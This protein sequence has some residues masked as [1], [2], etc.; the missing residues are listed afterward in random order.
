MRAETHGPGSSQR[1]VERTHL[2]SPVP[3]WAE[4][5]HAAS[6][7]DYFAAWLSYQCESIPGALSAALVLGPPG[8]GPF[9]PMVFWPEP[10]GGAPRLVEVAEQALAER[11][12]VV[13]TLADS[14]SLGLALPLEFDGQLHGVLA[15]ELDAAQTARADAVLLGL[16]WGAAW[17]AAYLQRQSQLDA[18]GTEQ[19]LMAV[20]D[21]MAAVLEEDGYE[22]ACRSLVT[23]LATRLECDRVSLG[24]VRRGH[25]QTVALSHSAQTARRSNLI[26]AVGAAM[27][28]AIDQKAV[29]RYP[30]QPG[31]EIVVEREHRLLATEHGSGCVLTV[32]LLGGNDFSGALTFERPA[33][34][35][36]AQSDID[37]CQAVAAVSGRILAVKKLSE[38]GLARHAWDALAR[39]LQRLLGPRHVKRK[40][41]LLLLG[42]ASVFFSV[43]RADYKISAPAT[44]EGAIRRTVATP[45]DGFVAT[46]QAR[47]GD[48]VRAG[49]VLATLDQRDLALERLKWASQAAQY[50][51]QHQEAVANRDRAKAQIVQAL[52]DQAH[53][54]VGLL[55]EQLTRAAIKAPF[56]G[57]I[58]KGDL[59]QSLGGAVRRGDVLFEITPLDA[60]RVIVEIDERDI[61]DIAV[62]QKGRLLL[63]AIADQPLPF[64]VSNITSV[65]TAR[66]GRN[67]FRVEALMDGAGERLRPGMEGV[68]KID[69]ENRPLFWIWTHRLA[70]WATLLLWNYLP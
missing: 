16:R 70:N 3:V 49:A 35:P 29:I 68:G 22:A 58:V 62:G 45:F 54:Q 4:L 46:A 57:V 2:V 47:A 8:V 7:Q 55:D 44:L 39:Q 64:S 53:A 9:A 34:M 33:S 12:A 23:E 50:V 59:S 30:A 40:L 69:I 26:Q 13:L 25:T 38:R 43:A 63:S 48:V 52:Y 56:D 66:E 28:E 19:R 5:T 60:Y 42:A 37:L 1:R 20:L 27:D 14:T 11:R 51:K 15:F 61:A 31:D 24:V 10:Q 36:F 17:V 67:Y 41:T 32:P 21:Q 6:P 65:T 18:F